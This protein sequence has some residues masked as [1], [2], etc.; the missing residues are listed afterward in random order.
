MRSSNG[1]GIISSI[2][3]CLFMSEEVNFKAS[4]I[5]LYSQLFHKIE[6]QDSGNY[7]IPSVFKHI[8]A[9]STPIPNAPPKHLHQQ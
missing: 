4:L 1:S 6:E 7:R 3:F 5:S 9:I 2:N 8:N